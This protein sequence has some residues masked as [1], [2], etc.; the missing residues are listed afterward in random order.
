MRYL[1][2]LFFLCH[3]SLPAQT[4]NSCK[5]CSD[6]QTM[7]VRY[8]I[9]LEFTDSKQSYYIDLLKL[10]LEEST[11]EFGAYT[12]EP[13][14]IEMPQGRTSLMVADNNLIDVTWRMT[15]AETEQEL[16][17]VYWPLLKGLMGYR[18]FIINKDSAH[19]FPQSM[20]EAELKGLVAGQGTGWPDAKILAHNGYQVMP[21]PAMGLLNMLEKGRLDYFPRAVHEPWVE[22]AQR[23]EFMV[24][25]NILLKYPAPM[26]FF[27]NKQN[28]LLQRRLSLGLA[29][30]YESGRFETF[31][32]QHPIT[33]EILAKA[34]L[35]E[36]QIFELSNPLLTAKAREAMDKVAKYTDLQ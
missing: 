11:Q 7:V 32:K 20:T 8:H 22:I 1:A 28:D 4:L 18:I 17:A 34:R 15:S 12:L 26:F 14:V 2:F 13:V 6:D 35:Q 21:S 16:Q 23:D 31:F 29:R 10:A 5:P 3:F 24:E 33:S 25:P 9:S 19:R 27:V 36:R 30:A